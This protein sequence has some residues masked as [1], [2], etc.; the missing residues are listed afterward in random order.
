MGQFA[1]E[2]IWKPST[3]F[4]L[5]RNDAFEGRAARLV[6]VETTPEIPWFIAL[7]FLHKPGAVHFVRLLGFS[8]TTLFPSARTFPRRYTVSTHTEMNR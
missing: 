8:L 2:D 5:E 4:C 7:S 3:A 1:L 6:D